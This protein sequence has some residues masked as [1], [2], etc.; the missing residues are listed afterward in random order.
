MS[1]RGSLN[2]NRQ[3]SWAKATFVVVFVLGRSINQGHVTAQRHGLRHQVWF[4]K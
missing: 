4:G 2:L 3:Y 1:F